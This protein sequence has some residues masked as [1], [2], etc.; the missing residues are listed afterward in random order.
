MQISY[1][2][3]GIFLILSL[4][5]DMAGAH[6]DGLPMGGKTIAGPG[7]AAIQKAKPAVILTSKIPLRQ[8]ASL[9]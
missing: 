9:S 4:L 3:M 6:G 2:R 7:N 8:P 5:Y 1:F